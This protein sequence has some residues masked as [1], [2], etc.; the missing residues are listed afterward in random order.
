MARI[1]RDAIA[2]LNRLI[3]L[4]R[5]AVEAYKEV[6][7]RVGDPVE[8]AQLAAFVGDHRRHVDELAMLVRNLGGD[9]ASQSDLRGA[10]ARG[11]V[12]VPGSYGG[13]TWL[14]ALRTREANAV[15]TYE[16]AVSQPGIPVDVL[17]IL[18]R[19]LHDERKHHSWIAV[20]AI[21]RTSPH[22]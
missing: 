7:T 17:A 9:P 3:Q 13:P 5:S 10:L 21:G 4:D 18:E 11:T 19:S 12:A 6:M 22:R 1:I 15:A 16:D 20:P 14:E 8:L 2:L